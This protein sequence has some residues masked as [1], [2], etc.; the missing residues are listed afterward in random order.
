MLTAEEKR[1]YQR[2]HCHANKERWRAKRLRWERKMRALVLTAKN[3]PCADCGGRWPAVV[4]EF[5]HRRK[6]AVA[7][8]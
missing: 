1:A 2:A 4:M 8:W 5:D 7:P 6:A 3:R